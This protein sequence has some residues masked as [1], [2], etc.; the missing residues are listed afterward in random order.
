VLDSDLVNIKPPS[1]Y[2]VKTI[3]NHGSRVHVLGHVRAPWKRESWDS[4]TRYPNL[5]YEEIVLGQG[6]GGLA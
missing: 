1:V 2:L 4:I 5:D 6:G 3:E